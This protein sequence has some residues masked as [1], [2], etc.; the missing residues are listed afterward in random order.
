MPMT[1]RRLTPHVGAEIGGIDLSR[2]VADAEIAA[3]RAAL[4]EAGVIFFRDQRLDHASHKAFGR[5]FGPLAV[6]PNTP[7]PPGHPELLPIHADATSKRIAGESWHSDVSCEAEPPLGSILHLH[8]VPETGGDTLFASC[9]AAYDALSP[10]LRTLLD[11]LTALHSGEV[12]Y[13]RIN[14]KLGVDDRG[15]VFPEAKHPVVRVHPESG[16]RVLFVNQMFTTR[17]LELPEEE[18]EAILGFLYRHLAR[19]EFQVRFTWAA[20]SVAFWDNRAVQ[21]LALWD[22][23][24]HTRSGFRVTIAGGAG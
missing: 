8:T 11:G 20:H 16:R 12:A 1:I 7:G 15:R 5:R 4:L 21:H 18:S 24:P 10:R 3:I 23:Y 9:G 6:H 13:R 17:I 14:A 22:Y 19:P 2:P